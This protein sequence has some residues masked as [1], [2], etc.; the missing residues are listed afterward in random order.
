MSARLLVAA[1]GARSAIRERAGIAT[2][3]GATASRRIVTTVAHE[4][5]HH[6][7]AEEHF[8]PAG[9]FAILPLK[10]PGGHRSS[11][12]WT[13]DARRPSASSR[14]PTTAS[15]P[16]SSGASACISARSTRSAAPRASARTLRWRADSSPTPRAGRR[17]RPCHPSD[18]RAGAQYGPARRRRAG[19]GDRRCRAAR[20]RSRRARGARALSALAAVRHHG[21]GRGDRRSQ[22]AVLQSLGRA[23]ARPA[24]SASA[25]STACRR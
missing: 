21:D 13:E 7:R 8:L 1:D 4:R 14:C 5:D 10:R 23:A 2:T 3:A 6:G 18:R 17:R 19:R 9:P 11:I 20:P 12:V 25:W 22:P 15:T 16:S 24:M